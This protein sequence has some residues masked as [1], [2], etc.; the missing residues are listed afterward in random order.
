MKILLVGAEFFPCG[1][2][3]RQTDTMKLIRVPIRNFGNAPKHGFCSLH[4]FEI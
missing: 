3:D 2:T 1:R 4:T